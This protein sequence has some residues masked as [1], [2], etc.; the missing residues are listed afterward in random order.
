[1]VQMLDSALHMLGPDIELLTDIMTDLGAKHV[2]Y[3]V[4]PNLF[5]IMGDCL[6]EVLEDLLPEGK[7][8]PSV[9]NSWKL[10]YGAL[11]A[12]LMKANKAEI[13][14]RSIQT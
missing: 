3:G 2:G 4:K 9:K 7:F 11:A 1:M 6:L 14:R 5:I 10:V 12:D 13:K 8:T